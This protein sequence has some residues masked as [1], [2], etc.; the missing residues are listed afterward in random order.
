[1][2]CTGRGVN[3]EGS[4][5]GVSAQVEDPAQSQT[6][7]RCVPLHSTACTEMLQTESAVIT[8]CHTQSSCRKMRNEI[9]NFGFRVNYAYNSLIHL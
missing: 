6:V 4:V 3:P 8:S 7:R 9:R 2:S 1:M 5:G